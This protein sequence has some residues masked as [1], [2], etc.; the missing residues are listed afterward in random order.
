VRSSPT[1]SHRFR[2]SG[3]PRHRAQRC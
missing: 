1:Q 3:R 2:H